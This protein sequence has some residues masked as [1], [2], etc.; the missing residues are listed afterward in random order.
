MGSSPVDKK[1]QKAGWRSTVGQKEFYDVVAIALK[2]HGCAPQIADLL[3][4]PF[5]H[6]VAFA[7]LRVDHFARAGD[8]ETLFGARFGFKFGHFVTVSSGRRTPHEA[9]K[10][11]NAGRAIGFKT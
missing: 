1:K 9:A 2:H 3:G 4:S 8:L 6:A 11:R 5:D 10:G 7:P